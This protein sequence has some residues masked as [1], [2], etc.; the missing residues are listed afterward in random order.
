MGADRQPQRCRTFPLA[1]YPPRRWMLCLIT[2]LWCGV[3]AADA[4]L[5]LPQARV[6]HLLGLLPGSWEGEAVETPVGP[7]DYDIAFEKCADHAVAGV[8]D[9]GASLHYWRFGDDAGRLRVRF[10]STF[11][12]NRRSTLLLAG[13]I[14]GDSIRFYAPQRELLTLTVTPTERRLDIRVFHYGEPHVHI[15]LRRSSREEGPRV[16]NGQLCENLPSSLVD[17]PASK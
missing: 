16:R 6:E 14:E 17:E 9:T 11:A 7:V 5:P 1:A 8:A 10:L 15:R 13:G 3:G 2:A 12:G 4:V